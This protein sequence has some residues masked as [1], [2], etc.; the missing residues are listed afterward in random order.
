MFVPPFAVMARIAAVAG[1]ASMRFSQRLEMRQG[2]SLVMTPQ[3]L[4][5]IKLLQLS[6]LELDDYVEAE[7]RA[8]SAAGARD[9][10]TAPRRRRRDARRARLTRRDA[11]GR[12]ADRSADVRGRPRATAS[13]EQRR[14]AGVPS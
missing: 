4:Q 10:P 12:R 7:A 5:A 9:E 8:Q 2:Q 13:S 11:I 6:N 14:L 1:I 3:L